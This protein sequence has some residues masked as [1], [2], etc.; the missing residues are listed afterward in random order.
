MKITAKGPLKS[1]ENGFTLIEMVVA[2]ALLGLVITALYS[3]YFSGLQNWN[4]SIRQMEYQ[5]SARIAM[6]KMIRELQYAH[7]VK[8]S[9][10]PE[11]GSTGLPAE[12][13]YFRTYVEGI[14][15]RHSFRLSGTQLNF[16]LRWNNSNNI[17]NTTVVALGLSRL[18]FIIDEDGTVHITVE[19]GEGSSATALSGAVK[20]RN[21]QP[22]HTNGEAVE[23][24]AD[25]E[26]NAD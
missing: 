3:F 25:S 21:F 9:V 15:T 4:H 18:E 5:Q 2:F 13:I 8:Y 26:N 6:D 19:A 14:S 22:H 20:P 12:M 17:R 11:K 23:N 10:D 16:D 24:G 7:L 1:Q